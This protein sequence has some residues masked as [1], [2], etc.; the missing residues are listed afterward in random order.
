VWSQAETTSPRPPPG[1]HRRP[2]GQNPPR[3]PA[4][5]CHSQRFAAQWLHWARLQVQNPPN[6]T[7]YDWRPC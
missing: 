3:D 2:D 4:D 6:T 1:P 7:R 5:P